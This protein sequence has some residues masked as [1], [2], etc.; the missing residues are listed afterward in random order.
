MHGNN[1]R[2]TV[3]VRMCMGLPRRR[4]EQSALPQ[5]FGQYLREFWQQGAMTMETTSVL[6]DSTPRVAVLTEQ[7]DMPLV[8]ACKT[9]D[10]SAFEQ[11]VKRYDRRLLRIAQHVTHNRE[12]AED[13]VQEAF[14]KVFRKLTQFQ[15]N[16][17]FSTWLIRITVNESLMKLRKQRSTRE[18][19]IHEDF[20]SEGD[21]AR[22]D[23]T[24][25]APDP[26]EQYRGSEL[27]NILRS[28]LQELQPALRVVFVLRDVERLSTEETAEA[29]ELTSA[30]VKARLC[31]ARLQLRERLSKYFRRQMKRS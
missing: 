31:R 25:W 28:A 19:S 26:E 30:A 14:L 21:F 22:F 6:D 11:L 24:D 17:R 7:D 29:L 13:A 15:G 27:R 20:Q 1:G 2:A 9:G 18:V 3:V 10:V 16:S 12:D 4:A 8:H 5:I 23:L